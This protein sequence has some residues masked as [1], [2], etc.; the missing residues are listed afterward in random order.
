V[1]S[2]ADH[3]R[4]AVEQWTADP[5]GSIGAED[6]PIADAGPGSA[7]Y[8]ASLLRA[9][10][11]Y[12]PW[13]ADALD[14][15]GASGRRLLDVGC[16]QGVDLV[17]FA[18]AGA[19]VSGVD[20]T[21]RHVELAQ[22]HLELLGL[23]ADVRLGDAE[24]LPFEDAS[25]DRVTSNGVLHHTPDPHAAAREI[26]RI[27]RPGGEARIVLYHRDSL[28]YWLQQF[29][30][31]GLLKGGLRQEGSMDAVLSRGVERSRVAAR[32]L[33]RVTSRGNARRLLRDAG[34][35]EVRTIV[36]HLRPEDSFL[37][38]ALASRLPRL[39]DAKMLDRVGRFAG[40]YVVAIGRRPASLAKN[41]SAADSPVSRFVR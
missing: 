12:S 38:A 32:P 13:L 40:W 17:H 34:L 26:A 27:L 1:T 10:A 16:G 11:A 33:V 2:A 9:K 24:I 3:K 31:T 23:D 21:P 14:Y 4:R 41:P 25:F 36:R 22:R 8:L 15:A 5:C 37:T 18:R 6:E 20:L 29:L 28:H 39:L 19:V 30:Y 35:T 7:D